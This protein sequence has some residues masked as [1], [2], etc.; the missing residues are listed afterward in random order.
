MFVFGLDWVKNL[1]TD[2]IE[3]F[4]RSALQK[5]ASKASDDATK[6]FKG[7]KMILTILIIFTGLL[8]SFLVYF[9]KFIAVFDN[10]GLNS[11]N[12]LKKKM[13]STKEYESY[14]KK[15]LNI[16]IIVII[17]FVV[18]IFVILNLRRKRSRIR[19]NYSE[20]Y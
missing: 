5:Q 11:V 3:K 6:Y 1:A 2:H 14:G 18:T 20:I 12:A 7:N 15:M 10:S 8:F 19:R 13:N 9:P 16:T 4:I 17:A